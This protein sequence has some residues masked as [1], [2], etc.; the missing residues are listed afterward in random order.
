MP[1]ITHTELN[2]AAQ[3]YRKELL[4]MAVLGLGLTLKH[5]TLRTGIR[6]KETV[7]ELDGPVEL[8]P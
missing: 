7:G 1:Q 8:M 4:I 2:T 3:K 5:M 6:Y